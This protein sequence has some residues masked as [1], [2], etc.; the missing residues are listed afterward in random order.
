M[1]RFVL[2]LLL[3]L[4]AAPAWGGLATPT[5]DPRL[6]AV[7]TKSAD[8]TLTLAD[9]AVNVNSSGANRTMTLPPVASCVGYDFVICKSASAN[10]VVTVDADGSEV[11]GN[12]GATTLT[13]Y[14]KGEVATFR[15]DGTQW[16]VERP[17]SGDKKNR[18]HTNLAAPMTV[19]GDGKGLEHYYITQLDAFVGEAAIIVAPDPANLVGQDVAQKKADRPKDNWLR[20]LRMVG[21]PAANSGTGSRAVVVRHTSGTQLDGVTARGFSKEGLYDDDVWNKEI[22]NCNFQHNGKAGAVDNWRIDSAYAVALDNTDGNEGSNVV[23]CDNSIFEGGLRQLYVPL[24]GSDGSIESLRN[25]SL[26]NVQFHG[27]IDSDADKANEKNLIQMDGVA[28]PIVFAGCTATHGNEGATNYGAR[29]VINSGTQICHVA[30]GLTFADSS[31]QNTTPKWRINLQHTEALVDARSAIEAAA[32]LRWLGPNSFP[33]VTTTVPDESPN[34]Y[35]GT[36]SANTSTLMVPGP[37]GATRN[38]LLCNGS[39]TKIDRDDPAWMLRNTSAFAVSAWFKTTSTADGYVMMVSTGAANGNSRAGINLTRGGS[40]VGTV[41]FLGRA[42]DAETTQVK[43]TTGTYNDGVWHHAVGVFDVANDTITIYMD[44]TS[45]A[46]TGTIA[47]TATATSDTVPVRLRVGAQGSGA[48]WFDG[49]ISDVQIIPRALSADEVLALY[50]AGASVAAGAEYISIAAAA[51]AYQ[52]LDSDLTAI[53]ALATTSFGRG[54]LASADQAAGRSW[55]GLGTLATQDANNVAITGGSVTGI[56]DLAVADGGTGASTA[57]AA[58]SNLALSV[59]SFT[60]TPFGP[61]GAV[62]TGD[63]KF[64]WQVP[65]SF[66]GADIT[67][68]RV[69]VPTVSTSG[70]PNFDIARTRSG[71]EVDVLSTNLT[72]DANEND[73]STAATAAVINTSNDDLATG[74]LI[75]F[76]CDTA[77]TGTAGAVITVEATK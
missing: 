65:S 47:F 38:G 69:Y 28:G 33:A 25:L 21:N 20:N 32:G 70:L 17:A 67:S 42:G 6:S 45:A 5:S 51:A 75:R 26:A 55:L 72:L 58:R 41:S 29:V 76:D 56:T 50:K 74:D 10:Y 36:A 68:V 61:I 66:N 24:Q 35:S 27:L 13:L 40:N 12:G 34:G 7:A 53:A 71:S 31:S 11:F 4:T 49:T 54:L 19:Y 9:R 73:S 60:V 37:N 14:G 16:Q 23:R 62:A 39:S 43:R 1:K 18:L 8:Y 3:I 52:P 48:N 46:Q 57:A 44:G 77:G 64:T 30:R 59:K 63:G 15:S 2:S 22:V